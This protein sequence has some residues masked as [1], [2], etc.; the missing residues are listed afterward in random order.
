MFLFLNPV[1]LLVSIVHHELLNAHVTTTHSDHQLP[2]DYLGINLLC[3]KCILVVAQ[4]NNWHWTVKSIYIICQQLVD[5]IS[6][7]C[8]VMLLPLIVSFYFCPCF[9][10]QLLL[11]PHSPADIFK[12]FDH[13][14]DFLL[15][16]SIGSQ[17]LKHVTL[18]VDFRAS[19]IGRVLNNLF[20]KFH[21][22]LFP[23]PL[24]FLVFHLEFHD[25][26]QYVI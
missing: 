8:S 12:V 11:C 7:H 10:V 18:A 17:Q 3:A 16:P 20:I 5:N 6:L 9:L 15:H 2:I 24:H 22:S 21:L 1:Q 14:N 13:F 19:L 25:T 23:F 4:P 26:F